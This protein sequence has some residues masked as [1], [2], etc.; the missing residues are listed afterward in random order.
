MWDEMVH[1]DGT[2]VEEYFRSEEASGSKVHLSATG[3]YPLW[4]GKLKP[5][6]NQILGAPPL[7]KADTP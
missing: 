5:L 6:V 1:P 7:P 2:L 3:G 4:A